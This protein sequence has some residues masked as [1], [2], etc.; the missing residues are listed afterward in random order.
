MA[1]A[2]PLAAA[3]AAAFAVAVGIVVAAVAAVAVVA[4]VAA[5]A[6]FAEAV[7]FAVAAAVAFAVEQYLKR[8]I[9]VAV[10]A[11][12]QAPLVQQAETLTRARRVLAR[13]L[14]KL[15]RVCPSI[16]NRRREELW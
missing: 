12:E 15:N 13:G 8:G 4:I 2:W 16:S 3:E 11:A 14:A 7:A 10:V 5:A 9:A 1:L 6:A